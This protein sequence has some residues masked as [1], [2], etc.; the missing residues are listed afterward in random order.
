MP[1][2]N[3]LCRKWQRLLRLQDWDVKIRWATGAD[4]QTGDCATCKHWDQEKFALIRVTPPDQ[5]TTSA[6]FHEETDVEA[7]VVH[8]LLHLHFAP[9]ESPDDSPEAT[10]QEQAINLIACALVA[11]DRKD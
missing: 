10:S 11:L 8:E 6:E 9:F 1:D 2:L 5:R 3:R 4:D 7:D